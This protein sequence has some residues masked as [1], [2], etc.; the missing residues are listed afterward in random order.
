MGDEVKGFLIKN[1]FS[2]GLSMLSDAQLGAV[3]RGIIAE[4]NG[5]ACEP[6]DPIALVMFKTIMPSIRAAQDSYTRRC[7]ILRENGKKGGR[8]KKQQVAAEED[9]NPEEQTET[10]EPNGNSE[11]QTENQDETKKPNGYSK[12]IIERKGIEGNRIEEILRERE[13]ERENADASLTRSQKQSPQRF[14]PPTLEEVREYCLEAR[15]CM[16]SDKFYDHFASNGWKVSGKAPMKDWKAAARNWARN[17]PSHQQSNRPYTQRPAP[18]GQ[19][20]LNRQMDI[21]RQI[22][23]EL[24]AEDAARIQ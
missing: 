20:D 21:N 9:V 1:E 7:D 8:P 4:G 13:K 18:S 10:E 23:A 2:E 16:D 5:E 17:E 14:T 6:T 15:L 19:F 24:E 11:N 12:T 22:L 3:L